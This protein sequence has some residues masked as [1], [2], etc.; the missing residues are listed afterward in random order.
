MQLSGP[1]K[2]RGQIQAFSLLICYLFVPGILIASFIE[3]WIHK[4]L[5]CVHDSGLV[6]FRMLRRD[7]AAVS[8]LGC[9]RKYRI[10]AV[11]TS[12]SPRLSGCGHRRSEQFEDVMGGGYQ[13][14]FTVH[15]F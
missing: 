5:V 13:R 6:V 9:F 11:A 8:E 3:F 7:Q 2:N 4:S 15:L 1:K 14:P 12:I 10:I